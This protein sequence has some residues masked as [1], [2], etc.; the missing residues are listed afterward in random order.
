MVEVANV[1]GGSSLV[2][3]GKLDTQ[4]IERGFDKVKGGF[5][6]VG[7]D[8]KSVF[9]DFNRLAVISK[10]LGRLFTAAGAAAGGMIAGAAKKA[11]ALAGS[12][13]RIK[14]ATD[15]MFRALG[16][17]LAPVFEKIS[18][19]LERFADWSESHPDLFAGVVTSLVTLAALKWTGLLGLLGKL[20]AP[21]VAGTT[22]AGLLAVSGVTGIGA[23]MLA[24]GLAVGGALAEQFKMGELAPV[25][26]PP[27]AETQIQTASLQ[28]LINLQNLYSARTTDAGF[29]GEF[30]P[31]TDLET[32][33]LYS[34]K[35]MMRDIVRNTQSQ[36]NYNYYT[37]STKDL[38]MNQQD[39]F[40]S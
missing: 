14:V 39:S 34:N 7:R 5:N 15:R 31:R 19:W 13:A 28:E 30:T 21:I 20:G 6:S 16:E 22:L 18:G 8:S 36:F 4:E 24:G 12:M 37:F 23:G 10:S 11:P 25:P 1:A 38:A 29:G 17:G 27:G 40:F 33:E 9:G 2:I 32:G 3:K 26:I 35:H